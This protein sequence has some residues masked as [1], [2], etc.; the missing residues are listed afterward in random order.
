MSVNP[1]SDDV[2]GLLAR[3]RASGRMFTAAG[4]YS[5]A[6]DQGARDAEPVVCVH[7]VPA[8]REGCVRSAGPW[9]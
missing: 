6:M 2:A 9:V 1:T 7:G 3:Y 5:F 8:S 4:I